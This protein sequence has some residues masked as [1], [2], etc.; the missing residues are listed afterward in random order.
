ME[1]KQIEQ[2]LKSYFA[3]L[4]QSDAYTA[5]ALYAQD[6]VFMPTEAPTAVGLEQLKAAYRH[7][8]DAIKL[9]V[10]FKIEEIVPS[11]EYAY[12]IT[13]SNGEVTILDKGVTLPEKNRELFVLKKVAGDWKIA[14]YMFNKSSRAQ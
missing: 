7:V 11:G 8:F 6:G 4:N 2:L 13:S 1:T 9:N 12:V 3:A 5:V 14:R 10:S